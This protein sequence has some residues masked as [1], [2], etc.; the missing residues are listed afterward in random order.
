MKPPIYPITPP[1]GVPPSRTTTE[2]VVDR[3]LLRVA[4]ERREFTGL[5][6]AKGKATMMTP[7]MRRQVKIVG[8]H[9]SPATAYA[10]V[11]AAHYIGLELAVA[12]TTTENETGGP[13]IFQYESGIWADSTPYGNLSGRVL[14]QSSAVWALDAEIRGLRPLIGFGTK[15]LT[16]LSLVEGAQ[17]RGGV[18]NP[19]HGCAEGDA[20]FLALLRETGSL[21]KAFYSYNGSGQAAMDYANKASERVLQWRGWLA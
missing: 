15:Q 17:A 12:C 1:Y 11:F 21:W 14:T 19:E 18:W 16:S 9:L 20:F 13:N 8:E 2:G 10:E 5:E 6:R 4:S 7:A 3:A